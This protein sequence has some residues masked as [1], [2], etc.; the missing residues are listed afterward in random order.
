VQGIDTIDA[1]PGQSHEFRDQLSQIWYQQIAFSGLLRVKLGKLDASTEFD[2]SPTAQQ[3]LNRSGG[4]S[5]TLF[6]LPTFPD[7]ATSANL[8]INPTSDIQ[9]GLGIYDGSFAGGTRTGS[10]G[11]ARFLDRDDNLLLISELDK[12]WTLALP[13]LPGRVGVG[14]WF[15]TNR[16]PRLNGSTADGT[17]APYAL[18]DQALWRT[19][20][21]NPSDKT[22]L[23]VFGMYG[24]ADPAILSYDEHLGA[25]ITWTGPSAARPNDLIGLAFQAV[26]FSPA[27]HP[28][29]PYEV[30][31]E[32]FYQ[33][34]ITPWFVIKPDLQ[35]ITGPG[36]QGAPDALA[37]TLRLQLTL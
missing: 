23:D 29:T 19:N 4:S 13:G 18:V 33:A 9:I 3:F 16:L 25:G 30:N 36:G 22:G 15:S 6:T 14:G 8:F 37:L 11:P 28:T 21:G 1:F 17:G 35:Y 32:I 31:Y 26:H 2:S 10:L 5:P 12:S 20:P 34:Q 24:Y 7:P 27:F